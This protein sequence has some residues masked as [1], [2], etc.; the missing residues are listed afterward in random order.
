MLRDGDGVTLVATGGIVGEAMAA[1]RILQERGISCRVLSMHTVKPVDE[2]A[3]IRAA[4]E[5]EG[6]VTLE[7]HMVEA[8]LGGA[9]AETLMEAGAYPGFFLRFG[10]RSTFSSITGSQSYL[11]GV[12]GLDAESV[13]T[14]VLRRLNSLRRL[15]SLRT[16]AT[17]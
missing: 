13:A 6:I 7:E 8:G 10:L 17:A 5:T 9:V 12:Y 2:E 15:T 4:E 3:L 16:Q 1:A 14:A 11:R